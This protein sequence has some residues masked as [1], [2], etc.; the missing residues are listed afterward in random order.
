V[1]GEYIAMD[2][3]LR[4]RAALLLVAPA[5]TLAA[6][7]GG[8]DGIDRAVVTGQVTLEGKPVVD[9]EIRFVPFP[10]TNGPVT[11]ELIQNGSY[12]CEYNGGVPV[13][14]HRVEVLAWDPS[15]PRSLGKGG[16]KRPQWV[17][18]K[19]NTASELIES[20]ESTDAVTKNFDL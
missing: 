4:L 5:I 11:I 8:G 16:P 13:G 14:K 19:Y 15:V 9:G 20:I 12:K 3:R 17:P 18:A 1:L 6:G 10:E 2:L 7:C